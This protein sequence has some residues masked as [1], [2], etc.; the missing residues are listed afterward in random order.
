MPVEI[1]TGLLLA[2]AVLL[3]GVATWQPVLRRPIAALAIA[4]T[5]LYAA[6]M[7][8]VVGAL[9]NM[10]SGESVGWLTYAL[11]LV[12]VVVGL[13][14]AWYVFRGGEREAS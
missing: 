9:S 4:A 12:I 5:A 14:L 10:D 3:S 13:G 6:F 8:V 1:V 11:A 7:I 2:G